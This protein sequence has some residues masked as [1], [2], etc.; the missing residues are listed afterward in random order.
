MKIAISVDVCRLRRDRH[1]LACNS[2]AIN[3]LDRRSALGLH[4]NFTPLK[5]RKSDDTVG[6]VRIPA[7]PMGLRPGV[8]V[9][10][11][12]G[13]WMARHVLSNKRCNG[14]SSQW[15]LA[16]SSPKTY[17]TSTLPKQPCSEAARCEV[18]VHRGPRRR[19]VRKKTEQCAQFKASGNPGRS[20]ESCE[21]LSLST[22]LC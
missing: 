4:P 14:F 7:I 3:H 12:R 18:G 11:D 10:A 16:A 8:Q 17:Q 13:E 9:H 15:V 22:G 20:Y 2:F 21:V 6:N 19:L 1:D 5:I